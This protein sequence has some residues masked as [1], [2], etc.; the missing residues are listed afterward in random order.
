MRSV[1]RARINGFSFVEWPQDHH[2]IWHVLDQDGIKGVWEGVSVRREDTARPLSHGS[3]DSPVFLGS[4]VI[5]VSGH[6]SAPSPAALV[7][8]MNRLTGLLSDGESGRLN[9]DDDMGATWIDVR[10]GGPTQITQM[11]ATT[12]KFLVTFFAAD[13]RRFGDAAKVGGFSVGQSVYHYGNHPAVLK[14]TVPGPVTAPYTVAVGSKQFTVTQSLASGQT[15]VLDTET[16]TVT[17]NGVAQSGVVS[18]AETLLVPA[19]ASVSFTG[20]SGT[21]GMVLNTYA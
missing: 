4:R 9:L 12:A 10:L 6:F 20:P 16:A 13:P 14:P 21:T 17:R 15:H 18:R 5:P 3:F 19:G 2:G 11:D 8:E 1:R 7:H